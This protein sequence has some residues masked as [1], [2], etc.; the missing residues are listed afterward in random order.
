V[1]DSGSTPTSSQEVW[2]RALI[3]IGVLGVVAGLLAGAGWFW[4][5]GRVDKV[6]DRSLDA[7]DATLV[8]AEATLDA[9]SDIV[10]IV[11]DLARLVGEG[12][13]SLAGGIGVV[14]GL[15]SLFSDDL[16]D[17][18]AE[19]SESLSDLAGGLGD[20]ES[21]L[22]GYYAALDEATV[23]A[24]EA[25][26]GLSGD[27]LAVRLIGLGSGLAFALAQ[28]ATIIVGMG[29]LASGPAA[30]I[31]RNREPEVSAVT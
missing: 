9:A 19:T 29:L 14:G 31:G 25:R 22:D 1:A 26:G 12:V 20:L 21:V 5:A 2:G 15:T 16:G 10:V 11:D 27:A 28:S 17:S 3:V 23:A 18:L 24:D 4:F 8:A 30:A 13:S 6:G 7:V